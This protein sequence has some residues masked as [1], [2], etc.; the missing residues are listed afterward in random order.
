M[1]PL[2]LGIFGGTFDPIHNGHLVAARAAL[3]ALNL[4][5]IYFVPT[6]SSLA[7]Q[8]SATAQQRAEMVELAIAEEPKFK[9]SR[10]DID[11]GS[12]T[13]TIDTLQS[14][15]RLHLGAKLYFLLGLDAFQSIA[16]WKDSQK[17]ADLAVFVVLSRPGYEVDA[18]GLQSEYLHTPLVID[19]LD[20]S[21]TDI[22]T[23]LEKSGDLGEKVPA[24]VLSYIREHGLYAGQM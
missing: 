15:A 11:R 21:S 5:I 2:R 19:A 12:P 22:R 9:M 1:S 8:H 6:W 7:K 13:F 4:D 3:E 10:V 23:Q 14:F 18:C 17:L 24:P 16:S 20:I